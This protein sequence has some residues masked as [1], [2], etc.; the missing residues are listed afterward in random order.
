[1]IMEIVIMGIVIH[2]TL[3]IDTVAVTEARYYVT[4]DWSSCLL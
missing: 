1:M 3:I 4:T 2:G